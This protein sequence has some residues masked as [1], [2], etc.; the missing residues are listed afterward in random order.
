M[1]L[2]YSVPGRGKSGGRFFNLPIFSG[3][4]P[5]EVSVVTTLIFIIAEPFCF[6]DDVDLIS[7]SSI[8]Q[9]RVGAL[10]PKVSSL[11]TLEAGTTVRQVWVEAS[12]RSL[13][14]RWVVLLS[15]LLIFLI[16]SIQLIMGVW[17]ASSFSK[18]LDW[19]VSSVELLFYIGHMGLDP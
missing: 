11:A 10:V 9:G 13:L 5:C 2:V 16:L 18:T 3:F 19:V 7:S 8:G 12:S 6:L 14:A 17:E 4:V 15:M 1:Y